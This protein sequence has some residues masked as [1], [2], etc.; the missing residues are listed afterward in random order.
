MLRHSSRFW[1]Y[2][3]SRR[4]GSFFRVLIVWAFFLAQHSLLCEKKKPTHL[5]MQLR[6]AFVG[7]NGD[8]DS[9]WLGMEVFGW[10]CATGLEL[11][12]MPLV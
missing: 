3:A 10:G 4:A 12:L 2:A 11:D 5:H 9:V 7:G 6:M 8:L 1:S